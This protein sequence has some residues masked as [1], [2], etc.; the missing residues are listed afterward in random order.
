MLTFKWAWFEADR[1]GSPIQCRS[2]CDRW[3][4]QVTP[5]LISETVK[6]NAALGRQLIV[7]R[8]YIATFILKQLPS[9]FSSKIS[10]YLMEKYWE[11]G[12]KSVLSVLSLATSAL[13]SAKQRTLLF[14]SRTEVVRSVTRRPPSIERGQRFFVKIRHATRCVLCESSCLQTLKHSWGGAVEIITKN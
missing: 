3:M 10:F 7:I 9:L 6:V 4:D 8:W 2:K 1:I 5:D 12:N 11:W 13:L 14:H